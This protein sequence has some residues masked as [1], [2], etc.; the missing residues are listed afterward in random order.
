VVD[1]KAVLQHVDLGHITPDWYEVQDTGVLKEGE[2]IIRDLL[3]NPVQE[4]A[5]ITV[6]GDPE[7]YRPDGA[8]PSAT[9]GRP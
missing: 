6:S 9:E 1:G 5:P 7:T 2:R 8:A 3:I 4:G